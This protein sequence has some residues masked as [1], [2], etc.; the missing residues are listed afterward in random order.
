LLRDLGLA[1]S[2]V[3]LELNSLGQPAERQAHRAALIAHFE[4]HAGALDEDAKR[5][6]HSNPLRLLDSKNPSMQAVVDAA[7]KLV[8]FLGTQS[9]AHLSAVRA[10]LDAAGLAYRINPRL[11]RGLDYYNL[12]VFEWITDRLG[13]Q[14]TVCGGG[15]YDGL[16]E[17][18]GGKPTPAVGWGMGIERMLLLLDEA[19]IQ[20]PAMPPD[21]YAVVPAATALSAA[22][23]TCEALRAAGLSVLMHAAGRDG[24]GSVKSQ[25]KRADASGARYALIFGDDELA[26]G[27]VS[28]KP[29]RD[30][31]AAQRSLLL[32][33]ASLWATQLRNA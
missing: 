22:M 3:R 23:S 13:S 27:E 33:E 10:A 2:D 8:D 28:L 26:R 24:W 16:F 6:L 9:L 30:A 17:Q 21:I 5:R 29:L 18:L 15:R 14:G 20:T 11:V 19:G 32:V 1:D 4:A 7:P 12:T 31:A 25:F